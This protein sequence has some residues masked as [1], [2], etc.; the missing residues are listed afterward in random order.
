MAR[1]DAKGAPRTVALVF[2]GKE[3][4][5]GYTA[6]ALH[7]VAGRPLYAWSLDHLTA[8]P[9]IVETLV[10]IPAHHVARFNELAAQAKWRNVRA[11]LI[12][13]PVRAP[14]AAL[15]GTA[16]AA[17]AQVDS[18]IDRVLVHDPAY[19]LLDANTI[20]A[21]LA[22]GDSSHVA[23]AATQA[24]DTLK[25]ANDQLL[26]ERTLP[27]ERMWQLHAP[28][29]AP[30]HLLAERLRWLAV[31]ASPSPV[32]AGVAWPWLLCVQMP[33]RI[34]P[35]GL[36]VVHIRSEGGLLGLEEQLGSQPAR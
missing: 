6:L 13:S 2:A 32:V 10:L 8:A 15:A 21:V 20:E 11:A 1:D 7:K 28:I 34:V 25:E 33:V 14:V 19:P 24:K 30:R 35:I 36:E 16:L 4:L 9:E 23:V 31:D 17:L 3:Q 22:L 26:V 18:G 12:A 5:P 27:R 29:C